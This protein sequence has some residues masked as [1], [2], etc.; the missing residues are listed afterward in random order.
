MTDHRQILRD[1]FLAGVER[2]KPDCLIRDHVTA[3]PDAWCVAG[4]RVAREGSGRLVVVGAGKASG[5]MARALDDLLGARI[6]AGAVVVKRGHAVPC[7]HI[8]TF[9]AGHPYPDAAGLAATARVAALC[10]AAGP[11]D[12]VIVLLSGGGSALLADAPPGVTLAELADLSKALVTSGAD[13]REIN[14]VRKHLS[15]VKGG[16]LARLTAPARL[17]SLILSDVVGDPLDVIASGPTVPDPSTYADAAEV[18]RRYGVWTDMPPA[19]RLVLEEGIAGQRAE[20]PKPGDPAL[21]R[22]VNRLIGNNRLALEACRAWLAARGVEAEIV[23]DRL[24]GDSEAAAGRMVEAL[25][26]LRRPR[27]LLF[28]GETTLAVR[29][30]GLGGRNQHLALKAASLLRGRPGLTLLAA[31]TDGTDGPTDAA[32][33]VV[34]GTTCADAARRGIDAE[35]A[36]R[37][38]DAYR[39]FNAAGG[40]V[41]TGPTLTNVMDVAIA[42]RHG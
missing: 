15:G 30:P 33:A 11:D 22:C 7:R 31:G 23:T 17:V 5:L 1:A 29:G 19:L 6:A 42:W 39:F 16:Q 32:G 25:C 20:T 4:E 37:A 12:C 35:A 9:E 40:H 13:I 28:G 18:C 2:V 36:L 38:F 34:D 41:K 21:A 26:A 10:R 3:A 8:E 27:A 24:D 14:A